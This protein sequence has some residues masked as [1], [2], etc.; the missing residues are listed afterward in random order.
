VA[1]AAFAGFGERLGFRFTRVEPDH[2]EVEVTVSPEHMNDVGRV[3]G[4][5]LMSV[6][7]CLGGVGTRLALLPGWGTATIE[8]H[9]QFLEGAKGPSLRAVCRPLRIGRRLSVWRTEIFEGDRK[10]SVT[11]QTQ[12]HLEPR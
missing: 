6:A 12:L 2:V 3:H 8:S 11:S 5:M 4:G 10:V 9:T 1:E 7:D